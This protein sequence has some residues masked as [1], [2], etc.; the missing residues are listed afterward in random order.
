LGGGEGFKTRTG[1]GKKLVCLTKHPVLIAE[2]LVAGKKNSLESDQPLLEKEICVKFA[3]GKDSIV[4][5]IF[6]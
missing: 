2:N 1:E 4:Y 3:F 5:T 6:M